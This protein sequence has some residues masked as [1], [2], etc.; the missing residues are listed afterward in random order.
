MVALG[1]SHSDLDLVKGVGPRMAGLA[2]QRAGL[3]DWLAETV[4]WSFVG[5][6]SRWSSCQIY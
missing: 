3:L 1:I 4:R 6:F 2:S 5:I